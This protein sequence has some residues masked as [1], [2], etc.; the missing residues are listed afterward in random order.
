MHRMPLFRSKKA[1][2]KGGKT[3]VGGAPSSPKDVNLELAALRA[4]KAELE[5]QLD[6][7]RAAVYEMKT[8]LD[9][10]AIEKGGKLS[11]V[12]ESRKPSLVSLN[13]ILKEFED[14][15][16]HE[17]D[18]EIDRVVVPAGKSRPGL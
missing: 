5:A 9:S 11:T 14:E 12:G 8:R 15:F 1:E 6:H 18:D 7:E 13:T 3:P 17:D 2:P 16:V 10:M 4:K